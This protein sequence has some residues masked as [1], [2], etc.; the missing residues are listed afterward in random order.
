MDWEDGVL[1][2]KSAQG[3]SLN[4]TLLVDM[5]QAIPVSGPWEEGRWPLTV[6]HGTSLEN[7]PSSVQNGLDNSKARG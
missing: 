5:A 1:F 4:M 6:Y 7:V 3:Q 2:V